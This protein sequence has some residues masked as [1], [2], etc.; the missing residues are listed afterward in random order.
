MSI[1]QQNSNDADVSAQVHRA[2]RLTASNLASHDQQTA[3]TSTSHAARSWLTGT[4]TLPHVR[5]DNGAWA[6]LVERDP[7]AAAIEAASH[8]GGQSRER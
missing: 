7:V 2:D 5:V 3:T 6:R 1:K 8:R 4:G